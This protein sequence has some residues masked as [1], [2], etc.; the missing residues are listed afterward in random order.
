MTDCREDDENTA[1]IRFSRADA[2]RDRRHS[3]RRRIRLRVELDGNR[4]RRAHTEDISARGLFVVTDHLRAVGSRVRLK[5]KIDGRVED[6]VGR[7]CW[8]RALREE[9]RSGTERRGFGLK[10]LSLS[11]QG[12]TAFAALLRGSP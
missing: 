11:R 3:L 1:I 12:Q 9:D 4:D 10:I 8:I 2:G 6:L 5:L 7:V